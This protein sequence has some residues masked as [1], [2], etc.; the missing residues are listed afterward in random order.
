MSRP[1]PLRRKPPPSPQPNRTYNGPNP[2]TSYDPGWQLFN[3]LS[4][5]PG[6][7]EWFQTQPEWQQFLDWAALSPNTATINADVSQ[8]TITASLA[9]SPLTVKLGG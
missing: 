2:P 7:K 3:N 8:T 5:F 4:D 9:A 6:A 1:T